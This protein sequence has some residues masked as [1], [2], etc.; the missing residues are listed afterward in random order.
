MLLDRNEFDPFL[1]RMETEDKREITYD[2]IKQKRL[3]WKAGEPSKPVPKPKVTT[4]KVLLC[5]CGGTERT[6]AFMS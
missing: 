2:I 5:V 1:K 6:S 4:R 3:W